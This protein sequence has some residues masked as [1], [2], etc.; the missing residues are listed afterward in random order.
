MQFP[1]Q[2][3]SLLMSTKLHI[4]HRS[5]S[6]GHGYSVASQRHVKILEGRI[7]KPDPSS[8]I[9]LNKMR[10][11]FL[12][13]ACDFSSSPGPCRGIERFILMGEAFPSFV[14]GAIVQLWH[15]YFEF[16]YGDKSNQV[17][18]RDNLLDVPS[19]RKKYASCTC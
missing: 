4:S 2:S 8:S 1:Q 11:R 14:D 12:K 17:P 10:H 19:P 3:E 16:R 5:S 9:C 18:C 13:R 6:L 15:M 7:S